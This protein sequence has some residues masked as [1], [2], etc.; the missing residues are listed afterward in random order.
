MEDLCRYYFSRLP[1]LLPLP[2]PLGRKTPNWL[3][4]QWPP[5]PARPLKWPQRQGTKERQPRVKMEHEWEAG[6]VHM[7]K[8]RGQWEKKIIKK[9]KLGNRKRKGKKIQAQCKPDLV[10]IRTICLLHFLHKRRNNGKEIRNQSRTVSTWEREKQVG[11]IRLHTE[12]INPEL[13]RTPS[14]EDIDLHKVQ[15]VDI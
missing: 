8:S 12:K 13:T 11:R 9:N 3:W 10:L 4:L 5:Y 6:V 1:N 7:D 14:S 2:P 15:K